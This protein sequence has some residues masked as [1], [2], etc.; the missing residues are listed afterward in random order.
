MRT[1][2]CVV[3]L[4]VAGIVPPAA[5]GAAVDD[6]RKLLEAKQY[7]KVDEVLR[8]DLEAAAPPAEALRV[9]LEAAMAQGRI[10]TAQRRV[11]A[12]LKVVGETDLD[13]VYQAARI[14]EQAGER[15]SALSRYLVYVRKQT[16]KPERMKHALEYLVAKGKFPGEYKKYIKVFGANERTWNMGMA[17][18]KRLVV[19]QETTHALDVASFMAEAFEATTAQTDQ[20]HA[21]LAHA[22]ERGYLGTEVRKRYIVPL[23]IMSRLRPGRYDSLASMA[24]RAHSALSGAEAAE[25]LLAMHAAAKGPVDVRCLVLLDRLRYAREGSSPTALARQVYQTLEPLYRASD[26]PGAYAGFVSQV[27]AYRDSFVTANDT[28]F[29]AET[30][31]AL[32]AGAIDKGASDRVSVAI[33]RLCER[34]AALRTTLARKHAALVAP[35]KA[36]WVTGRLSGNKDER[37]TQI[38]E[39]KPF[40]EAFSKGRG[41]RGGVEARVALIDWYNR[42]G[43]KESMLAAARDYMAAYPAGFNW[44]RIW[45]VWQSPLPS[46]DEKIALLRGQFTKSG[47]CEPMNQ[48]ITSRIA[49]DGTMRK[50]KAVQAMVREYT[51]RPKGTDAVMKFA[52]AV[53]EMERG[54]KRGGVNRALADALRAHGKAVPASR[55]A[56]GSIAEIA[57][58]DAVASLV[59]RTD[60]PAVLLASTPLGEKLIPGPILAAALDRSSSYNP[61]ALVAKIAP[62]LTGTDESTMKIW[63]ALSFARNAR[64]DKASVF[65]PYYGRMGWDNAARYIVGQ[66]GTWRQRSWQTMPWGKGMWDRETCMDELD[67]LAAMDGFA[68]SDEAV[69]VLVRS[70]VLQRSGKRNQVD[71]APSETVAEALWAGYLARARDARAYRPDVEAQIWAIYRMAG[72]GAASD[73]LDV[74]A[75]ALAERSP[76]QQVASLATMMRSIGFGRVM[77][78]KS[79]GAYL[80]LFVLAAAAYEKMT[81]DQWRMAGVQ[82]EIRTAVG[83]LTNSAQWRKALEGEDALFASGRKLAAEFDVRLFSGVRWIG[84]RNP[85]PL[86]CQTAIGAAAG[87]REWPAAIGGTRRLADAISTGRTADEYRGEIAAVARSLEEAGANEILY[88][89]LREIEQGARFSSAMDKELAILRARAAKG[90]TGLITVSTSNPAYPLHQAA[91]ALLLGNE[92][93]AWELARGEVAMFGK[94]WEGLDPDFVDWYVRQLYKQK[95]FDNVLS[96]ARGILQKESS[97]D[98]EVA[99]SI[100]LTVGDV[101]RRQEDNDGALEVYRALQASDRYKNTH[102]AMQARYRQVL[103]MISTGAYGEAEDALAQMVESPSIDEQAE[104]YYLLARLAD[105]QKEYRKADKYLSKVRDRVPDHIE[106]AFLEG[107]LRSK[108]PSMLARGE[109]LEIGVVAMET[110]AVPGRELIFRLQDSNLAIAKGSTTIPITVETSTGKDVETVDLVLS[111][112]G[113]NQFKGTIVASLGVIKAGDGTLQLRGED[114]VTYR[115]ADEFQR[116]HDIS[117]KPKTL[118]VKADGELAASAGRIL[119]AKEIEQREIELRLARAR[120]TEPPAWAREKRKSVRPGSPVYVQVTD[121]DRDVSEVP[122]VVTVS[123]KTTGGDVLDNVTLTET[124]PNTGVFQA[125]IPTSMPLPKGLAS[126][127]FEGKSPAWLVNSTTDKV[128]SSLDDGVKGKWIEADTMTSHAVQRVSV[129]LP[130]ASRIDSLSLSGRLSG[131]NQ[132]ELAVFPLLGQQHG[133]R[134][135]L[136]ADVA[137]TKPTGERT[138]NSLSRVRA[139]DLGKGNVAARYSGVIAPPYSGQYTFS[140]DVRG[141]RV[142]LSV[143]GK[144]VV[145]QWPDKGDGRAGSGKVRMQAGREYAFSLEFAGSANNAAQGEC[146]V[147]WRSGAMAQQEVPLPALYPGPMASRMDDLRHVRVTAAATADKPLATL[148]AIRGAVRAGQNADAVPHVKITGITPGRDELGVLSGTFALPAERM[149]TMKL[150]ASG[151]GADSRAYLVID[152]HREL[153]GKVSDLADKTAGVFLRKGAHRMELVYRS[154]G[155][156]A[157]DARIEVQI[158]NAEGKF[159]ALPWQWFSADHTPDLADAILPNGIITLNGDTFTA[160]LRKPVRLRTVRWNFLEFAGKDV[161]ASKITVTDADGNRVIPVEKDFTTSLTNDVLEIAPGDRIS[162]VYIDEKNLQDDSGTRQAGLGLGRGANLSVSFDDGQIELAHEEPRTDVNGNVNIELFTARRCSVGDVLTIV[163][164]DQDIDQTPQRDKVRVTMTT[165]A[166]RKVDLEILE[167]QSTG[168][169]G[170]AHEVCHTGRFVA[171]LRLDPASAAKSKPTTQPTTQPAGKVDATLKIAPGDEI[172]V[173]YL[174]EESNDGVPMDRICRLTEG[175]ASL[176][177]W[178]VQ[179]TRTRLVEDTSYTARLL[180]DDLRRISGDPEIQVYRQVVEH[181]SPLVKANADDEE[182]T[183]DRGMDAAGLPICS[184]RGQLRFGLLYPRLARNTGSTVKVIAVAESEIAAAKSEKRGVKGA[185]VTMD[186]LNE[187]AL[188]AGVFQGALNLQ[189]GVPGDKLTLEASA[190]AAE[191]EDPVKTIIVR[192]DDVVHLRLKDPATGKTSVQRVHMLADGRMEVLERTLRARKLKIHLGERFYLRVADPDKDVSDKRDTVKVA[193]KCSSGSTVDLALTETLVHSGV[194]TGSIE[195]RWI[196]DRERDAAAVKTAIAAAAKALTDQAAAKGALERAVAN[197]AAAKPA[198]EKAAAEAS[199]AQTAA[200]EAATK[201]A[202]ETEAANAAANAATNAKTAADQAAKGAAAA[203]A[204]AKAAADHAAKANPADKPAAAA[205]AA[206]AA[207][208]AVARQADADHAAEKAAPAKAAADKAAANAAAATTAAAA[209]AAKAAATKTAAQK[210]AAATIAADKALAQ[211]KVDKT[212][213]DTA[214]DRTAYAKKIATAPKQVLYA[215]FGDTVAFGYSDDKAVSTREPL[216]IAAEGS[217]L[218][219]SDGTVALFSKRY[220]DP[221]MAVKVSFLTAEALFSMGKDFRAQGDA[222]RADEHIARGKAIL[223]RALRD[224]PNTSL[225]AQG[226]FLVAT[227]AQELGSFSEARGKYSEVIQRWTKSPYAPKALYAIAQCYETEKNYDRAIGEYVRLTYLFPDSP[228]VTRATLRIGNHYLRQ[229]RLAEKAKEYDQAKKNFAV[230]GRILENFH[231]R[232]PKHAKASAALLLAGECYR[233]CEKYELA[234]ALFTKVT[235][236]YRDDKRMRAEALYW[237][238]VCAREIKD[239]ITAY[240]SLKRLT[241][242]YPE[243]DQAANARRLLGADEFN[244]QRPELPED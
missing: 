116:S 142:R 170:E 41:A 135:E 10:I 62:R 23:G 90:I 59:A 139:G 145:D 141:A 159:A 191:E 149:V 155:D 74:Y 240:R 54:R 213:A 2:L 201:A 232:H 208:A 107:E 30:L 243:S 50:D 44:S 166:G 86:L 152:G 1:V 65:A 174:D 103:L 146:Y 12:L 55:A 105:E 89:F 204:Q 95:L 231:D 130:D 20:L 39:A 172:V 210:A 203:R 171:R 143:G 7:D 224:Y 83:M 180:R 82:E 230:A 178:T 173:R 98:A 17:L 32:L 76:D 56:A 99:A 237:K 35:D 183:V 217:I 58:V 128:W 114:V 61:H 227:L 202:A 136:F 8:K 153:G 40:V 226:E 162:M 53:Y 13:L 9:S 15:R 64:G 138:V 46:T 34:N 167:E 132:M 211:A 119:T 71:A 45:Q 205:A 161:S 144:L 11:T 169:K 37:A 38:A 158:G 75:K 51:R 6:A 147:R 112:T 100:H 239:Y 43:D 110:V 182:P 133:V 85:V 94:S 163:V 14:S 241:W 218:H 177:G 244:S 101:R 22:A 104:A 148:A 48:L 165:S 151:V 81:D 192:G 179:R 88:A 188:E 195:P 198:A 79:K 190:A 164:A 4:V 113:R 127:T 123:V 36:A 168:S 207:A 222:A 209:A 184:V 69:Q 225:V 87:A 63:W 66:V 219:G 233:I 215:G 137:L 234:I 197:A 187:E 93:R 175:G 52:V 115:I 235:R 156:A 189:I 199:A 106:A 73:W 200:R 31:S 26:A 216:V 194:F 108:A 42:T 92:V 109:I 16:D 49:R 121:L 181:R 60:N 118:T 157:G 19:D 33:E 185:V 117:Y 91:Q 102:A 27:C 84:G 176:G 25:A 24:S 186:I 18:V 221:E 5:W 28:V 229:A 124:G 223:E 220:K 3:V 120:G 131:E 238:G 242:D 29:D 196:K 125:A 236:Q 228:D 47:Q 206:K 140:T 160:T 77:I 68:F 96:L 214:V 78:E 67:K 150:A 134:L 97:L 212:N 122:D 126:D 21:Y 154:A 57:L 193:L 80:R 111:G 129:R 72:P 70:A